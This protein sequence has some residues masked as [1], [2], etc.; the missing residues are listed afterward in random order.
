MDNKRRIII[1]HSYS[2]HTKMIANIIKKKLDCD[3]LELEPKYEFSSDYDEV[4][5]EYQN[6]EKDKST[7]VIK[8]ININLDNYD[9]III[10]SP[11]WWYSITPVVREFLK[12]NNLEGKT[13]IPFAT[14]AGWLGGTFKEIEE[15]CKNSS[16]T[17]EMNIVFG[18]YSD[19]LVT[20]MD[21]I[22]NWI[23]TL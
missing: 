2:G 9:E 16:V 3:V 14:N 10:G 7:V 12:E 11:V 20:S 1:Y 8:D 19:D 6:N 4:V 18:S 22:N 13:V 15:L 5:K 21:E 17:N 23:N